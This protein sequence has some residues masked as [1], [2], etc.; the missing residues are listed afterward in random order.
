MTAG[1]SNGWTNVRPAL[2]ADPLERGERLADVGAVEDDL[3]AVAAAGLDLRADSRRRPSTTVIGTPAVAAGPGI[4]LTGVPRRHRDRAAARCSG[5]RVSDPVGHPAGLERARLL[6]VLGLEVEAAVGE[7]RPAGGGDEPRPRSRS[8]GAASGG[9]ARRSARGRRGSRRD[10]TRRSMVVTAEYGGDRR[11]PPARRRPR[12]R[13]RYLR[14]CA[15]SD[16]IDRDVGHPAGHLVERVRSAALRRGR[17]GARRPEA[18][19]RPRVAGLRRAL[20]QRPLDEGGL[21][22]AEHEPAP[23]RA[24]QRRARP[25]P[26]RRITVFYRLADVRVLEAYRLI[27]SLAGQGA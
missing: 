23:R 4:G 3:G 21:P 26:A 22:G 12:R 8:T 9:R 18:P 1:S 10:P 15:N 13:E 2:V 20:G 17:S 27:Q 14:V 19:V 7:P 16:M 24:P 11:R 6:E 25:E 5:V